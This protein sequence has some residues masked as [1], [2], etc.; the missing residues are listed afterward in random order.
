MN[1]D[2]LAFHHHRLKRLNTETVESGS[3]VQ[4]DRVI[5]NDFFQDVP[6]DRLLLLHHFFRL[7]DG[8]DV[9]RLLQP[10]INER[11]EQFER[12]LLGQTALMQLE[13]RTD[14][15][16]GTS[17]VVHALAEQV[18]AEASLLAF[19]RVGERL[20][21]TVVRATQHAATASVV[22]QRV[23]RFLQHALFV[24]HD[25]FRSVQVHQLLQPVVAVDDA[26][27]KVVQIG[28]SK[29]AAVEWNQR[30]KLR[31]NHR[32][33]VEDH[34]VRL[35]A[36]LAECLDHFQTLGILEPLLQR[37]LVLHLLAQFDRQTV[38]VDA[39]QQ[40]LDRLSAH[41]RLESSG[42]VLLV[43]FAELGFVLDDLAL[44]YRSIAGF[45]HDVGFEIEHGL[46]VAQGNIKQVTDAAGQP[47][48]EPHVRAGRSQL[49]V[50][51]AFAA[52]FRQCDFHAALVANH[53]AVLHAFVLAA[54]AL[55]VRH[56]AKDVSAKQP[57]ALR[58]EGAVVDGLGL[59]HFAVRP[60]PDFLRRGQT[61]A[62]GVKVRDHICHFEWARTKQG[63][64][65]LPAAVSLP[66]TAPGKKWPVVS[67]SWPVSLAALAAQVLRSRPVIQSSNRGQIPSEP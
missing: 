7:L 20:Q 63:A 53:A 13:F 18:L 46:K 2:C 28:R 44:F 6:N 25:D 33:H 38:G 12:H 35:V 11:L 30:A 31:W 64:P 52:N 19:Q 10:V 15:D 59:R 9:A 21:R 34:P 58:L 1:L 16:H 27:V 8:G 4:Q 39:L 24:A 29:A 37:A 23:D 32:N 56:R 40:F 36:A 47:L 45:D 60:A 57:V 5:L 26:A 55:P 3:A 50:A 14:H 61:D 66:L 49:N 54:Q 65:P 43:E 42:T 41:H 51:K 62:N 67:D 22:E 17:R 48:E